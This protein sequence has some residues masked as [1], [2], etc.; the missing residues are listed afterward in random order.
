MTS[1]SLWLEYEACLMAL[2][3][4]ADSLRRDGPTPEAIARPMHADRRRLSQALEERT[5]EPLPTLIY[6][7]SL[8]VY[9]DPLRPSARLS[10]IAA[11]LATNVRAVMSWEEKSPIGVVFEKELLA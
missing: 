8:A 9:H 1:G 2:R 6:V 11:A 10:R 3:D 7:R 5:P 4:P